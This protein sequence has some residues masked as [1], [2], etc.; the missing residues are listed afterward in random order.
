MQR[1]RSVGSVGEYL[2]NYI[3]MEVGLT[4]HEVHNA[5]SIAGGIT[6]T[7]R[8]SREGKSLVPRWKCGNVTFWAALRTSLRVTLCSGIRCHEVLV[9][10]L[11]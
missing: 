11:R 6:Q 9:N 3:K 5:V 10:L 7:S 4:A 8:N 1:D 2:N